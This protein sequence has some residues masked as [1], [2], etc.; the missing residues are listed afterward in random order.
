MQEWAKV[1]GASV[2]NLRRLFAKETGAALLFFGARGPRKHAWAAVLLLAGS[3]VLLTKFVY[4]YP[5]TPDHI[6]TIAWYAAIV[7]MGTLLRNHAGPARIVGAALAT[8][9]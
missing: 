7:A 6:A 4:G 5:Y 1:A 9:V 2:R 3:D 8:S